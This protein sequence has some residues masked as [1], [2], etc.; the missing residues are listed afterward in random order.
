M[1][2]TFFNSLNKGVVEGL[3]F[4]GSSTLLILIRVALIGMLIYYRENQ[5]EVDVNTVKK[6]MISGQTLSLIALTIFSIYLYI[7]EIPL[8]IIFAVFSTG[9]LLILLNTWLWH[10]KIRNWFSLG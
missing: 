4:L 7:I 1:E 10:R 9:V 2:N 6:I 5:P 3:I 8:N